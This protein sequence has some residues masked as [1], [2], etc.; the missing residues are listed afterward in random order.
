MPEGEKGGMGERVQARVDKI[1]SWFPETLEASDIRI[2]TKRHAEVTDNALAPL[3]QR[4]AEINKATPRR[5]QKCK[6]DIRTHLTSAFDHIHDRFAIVDD[7]LWHFGGTAGGFHA[8][9]SASSRGWNASEHGAVEFFNMA[10][11]A[12]VER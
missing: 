5:E 3:L 4:E 11:R 2:L 9:V 12:G 7:E 1:R 8:S 10:W 6:I